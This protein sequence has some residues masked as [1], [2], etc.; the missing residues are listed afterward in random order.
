MLENQ[1]RN[2]HESVGKK[3]RKE[4]RARKEGTKAIRKL[5]QSFG[6]KERRKEARGSREKPIKEENGSKE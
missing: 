3:T 1:G 5:K 6:K 4:G 2:R